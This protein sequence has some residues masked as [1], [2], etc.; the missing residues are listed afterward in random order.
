MKYTIAGLAAMHQMSTERVRWALSFPNKV[1]SDPICPDAEEVTMTPAENI[2]L[3]Q[4][5]QYWRDA[6]AQSGGEVLHWLSRPPVA[7]EWD[8]VHAQGGER[9]AEARRL[10]YRVALSQWL[11]HSRAVPLEGALVSMDYDGAPWHVVRSV[12]WKMYPPRVNTTMPEGVLVT[13][14]APADA[15]TW[16]RIWN[17]DIITN[18]RMRVTGTDALILERAGCASARMCVT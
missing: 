10:G 6:D 13:F 2:L 3:A 4:M 18:V 11:A 14:D 5:A 15:P 12:E 1:V 8:L 9:D 17:M 16:Q 7:L